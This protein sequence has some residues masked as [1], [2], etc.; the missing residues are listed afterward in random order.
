MILHVK[1]SLCQS[2]IRLQ[3]DVETMKLSMNAVILSVLLCRCKVDD[4]RSTKTEF[5]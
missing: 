5:M 3:S 1:I 2:Y 4:F